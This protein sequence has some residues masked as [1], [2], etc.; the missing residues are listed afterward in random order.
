MSSNHLA[1]NHDLKPVD[2]HVAKGLEDLRKGRTHGPYAAAEE[3][4]KAMEERSSGARLGNANLKLAV[5]F[6]Q[7][8]ISRFVSGHGFSRAV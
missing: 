1:F 8:L 4:I 2:R 5:L 3:A 7:A 6:R